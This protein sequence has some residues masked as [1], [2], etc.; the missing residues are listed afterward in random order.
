VF[1]VVEGVDGS[2]KSTLAKY[3]AEKIPN[4]VLIKEN[5]KWLEEMDK[6]PEIAS[7]LFE[8]FCNER[9]SYSQRID[10]LINAGYVVISD[11]YYPSTIC[12][13][14]E[15]C[16]KQDC[17]KL[18]QIYN[19][20]YPQWKKPDLILIPSTPFAICLNRVKSRG[21]EVDAKF[22][23][24]VKRC[25]NMIDAIVDN[26]YYVKSKNHAWGIVEKFLKNST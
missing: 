7:M 20:Y 22:L 4:S 16:E 12:Y 17:K 5:T 25:Y 9:V 13:Q 10:R 3:I 15:N 14:I 6:F 11:R 2:G 21:E 18:L 24:K 19:K 1:I 26:V 8:D 23:R